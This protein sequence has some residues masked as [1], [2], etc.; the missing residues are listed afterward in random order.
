L[1][2]VSK[3]CGFRWLL[4]VGIV[5]DQPISTGRFGK[6]PDLGH[7]SKSCGLVLGAGGSQS[8]RGGIGAQLV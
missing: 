3:S 7:V 4:K 8:C 5:F 6:L 1:A 2:H